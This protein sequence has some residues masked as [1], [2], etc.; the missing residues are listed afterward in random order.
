MK[1]LVL[2][3]V[4]NDFVSGSLGSEWAKETSVKIGE[5]LKEHA[6]EYTVLATRDTHFDDTYL[7][8]L[9]GKMLPI[10]HCIKDTW[11]W[12][13]CDEVKDYVHPYE[14]IDKNTFMALYDDNKDFS[15]IGSKVY[16]AGNGT[17][18]EIIVC[19]FVTSICVVSNALYLRGLWPNT[20]ITVL[21]DLCADVSKEAH[22]AA[23][24]VMQNC[25][26]NIE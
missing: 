7:E 19:G 10:K 18:D 1:V 9:E 14:V 25:Q 6:G 13:L 12:E 8:S 15:N 21:K 26:I 24:M 2:I 5:F 4:Q 17:P 11:G 22:E 20:K 23:L 3:D 16:L